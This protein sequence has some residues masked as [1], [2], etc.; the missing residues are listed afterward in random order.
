[1]KKENNFWTRTSFPVLSQFEN[2]EIQ[3]DDEPASS[4]CIPSARKNYEVKT[5]YLE[6]MKEFSNKLNNTVEFKYTDFDRKRPSLYME[7]VKLAIEIIKSVIAK[8]EIENKKGGRGRKL[9]G[10]FLVFLPG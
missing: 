6:T 2:Y 1:M 9:F 5:Y 8:D 3:K 10:S 7:C 4:I